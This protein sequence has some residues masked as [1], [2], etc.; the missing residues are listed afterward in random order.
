MKEYEIWAEGY[1]ATGESSGA[2]LL[3]TSLGTSF[4]DAVLNYIKAHPDSLI[5]RNTET[6][7]ISEEAY[8]RRKSNWNIW[9]CDLFDNESDARKSFG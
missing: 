6:R 3:G 7:Y 1:M 8:K 5:E 9:A 2:T 4:D